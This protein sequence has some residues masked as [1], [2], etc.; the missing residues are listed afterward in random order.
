MT[1]DALED[2]AAN[3]EILIRTELELEHRMD[4]HA[5]RVADCPVCLSREDD[6]T[7]RGAA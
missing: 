1:D 5:V 6:G 3:V 7:R 2:V 4:G